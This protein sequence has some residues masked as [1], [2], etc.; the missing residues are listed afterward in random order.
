MKA[1]IPSTYTDINSG[2]WRKGM[3]STMPLLRLSIQIQSSEILYQSVRP[4]NCANAEGYGYTL[5]RFI[6]N[7]P[8]AWA[9]HCHI[10]WHMEAGLLMTF[11]VG[12]SDGLQRQ[13]DTAPPEWTALCI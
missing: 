6:S 13:L 1:L 2:S 8:G 12:G 3:A 7:N 10:T 11:L 9:L 5:I 4:L